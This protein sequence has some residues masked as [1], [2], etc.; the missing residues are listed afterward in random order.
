MSHRG[1]FNSIL[2]LIRGSGHALS[3]LIMGVF[4][5]MHG[6][7]M[8]W[9]IIFILSLCAAALMYSLYLFE[10]SREKRNVVLD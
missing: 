5:E 7:R 4:I 3:P 1:R 10:Q 6:V 9:P 8:V 2:P